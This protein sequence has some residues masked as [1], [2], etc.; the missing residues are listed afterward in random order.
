MIVDS[1]RPCQLAA[2]VIVGPARGIVHRL[3]PVTVME[4]Q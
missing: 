4:T 2:T 3:M 1:V